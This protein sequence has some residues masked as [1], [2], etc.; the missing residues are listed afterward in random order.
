MCMCFLNPQTN[1]FHFF[2]GVNLENVLIFSAI[3][4]LSMPIYR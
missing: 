3:N 2:K 1:A 4:V